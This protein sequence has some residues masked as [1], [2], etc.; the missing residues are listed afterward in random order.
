MSD[1][2]I[3]TGCLPYDDGSGFE[4]TITIEAPS[5]YFKYERVRLNPDSEFT[6]FDI[7][8]WPEVRDAIDRAVNARAQLTPTQKEPS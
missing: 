7:A 5:A 1:T 2:I 8:S 4:L 6:D 3:R